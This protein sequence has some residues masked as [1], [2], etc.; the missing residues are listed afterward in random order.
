MRSRS[1]LYGAANV[2]IQPTSNVDSRTTN[3]IVIKN[4]P[5][6]DIKEEKKDQEIGVQYDAPPSEDGMKL[7]SFPPNLYATRALD[8]QSSSMSSVDEYLLQVYQDILLVQDKTLLS[9][10]ISHDQILL[11]KDDLQE[12]IKRATGY[13]CV[14]DL[15]EP[16]I[17]CCGHPPPIVKISQ[18]RIMTSSDTAVEFKYAFLE[19]YSML[20]SK[21]HICLKYVLN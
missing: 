20:L 7:E 8:S 19:K 9:N 11:T 4:Y 10:L 16:E 12:V 15:I 6:G 13:D 21:Y 17:K 14:I 5:S 3:N 1:V 18:I 2:P